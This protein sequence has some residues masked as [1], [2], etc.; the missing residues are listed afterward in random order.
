MQIEY[1]PGRKRIGFENKTKQKS[2]STA[3]ELPLEDVHHLCVI[4][5]HPGDEVEY[6]GKE[7]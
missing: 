4:M 6:L 3:M 7:S 1:N 5:S 2:A